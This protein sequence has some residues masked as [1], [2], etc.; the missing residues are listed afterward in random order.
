M[1]IVVTVGDKQLKFEDG[2]PDA[3]I[4]AAVLQESGSE[5]TAE[6]ALIGAGAG[7]TQFGQGIKQVALGAGEKLGL[8]DEGATEAFT[9]KAK[10]EQDFFKK[11]P[12]GASTAGKVGALAGEILPTLAIPGGVQ[13]SLGSKILTGAL[14]NSLAEVLRFT[15]NPELFSGERARNAAGGALMGGA[16]P[17]AVGG[18]KAAGGLVRDT[19]REVTAEGGRKTI[20]SAIS[21]SDLGPQQEAAER[22]GVF[23]TPGEAVPGRPDIIA[24]E[25]GF[26]VEGIDDFSK[27]ITGRLADRTSK[28][29][30]QLVDVIESVSKR[31]PESAAKIAKG[32]TDLASLKI[33]RKFYN[34]LQENPRIL[35]EWNRMNKSK[36]WMLEMQKY[37]KDSA[38]RLDTFKSYLFERSEKLRAAGKKKAANN[39][40]DF[41]TKMIDQLDGLVPSYPAARGLAQLNIVSRQL[42]DVLDKSKVKVLDTETGEFT[43]DAIDFFRKTMKSDR[44]F[45]DLMKGLRSAPEARQKLTDIRAVL[46]SIEGSPIN[47]V[48]ASEGRKTP[49]RG[50]SGF[51]KAGAVALSGADFLRGRHNRAVVEYITNPIYTTELLDDLTPGFMARNSEAAVNRLNVI[52]SRIGAQGITPEQRQGE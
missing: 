31:D 49:V 8:V 32:Y 51:G 7:L 33:S 42:N 16:V 29:S 46:G 36:D 44:D 41:N 50:T 12:V 6:R 10:A 21:K 11:T 27:I 22:L 23:L 14:A 3:D 17:L 2:T 5:S 43:T 34:G 19:I 52:F 30:T 47:K 26:S 25:R 35:D 40:T 9:E 4:E 24:A 38:G 15:D 20:R 13:G 28:I 1:T 18:A 39:I 48:F 45:S 37:P